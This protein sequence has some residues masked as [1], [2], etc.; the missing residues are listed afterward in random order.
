METDTYVCN[1]CGVEMKWEETDEVHG[2]IWGCE[3][4]GSVFCS[5]CFIERHGRKNYDLMMR[6]YGLIYC[7][8]CW[9]NETRNDET[10]T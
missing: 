1:L 3:K 8:S 6:G 2:D 4:C 5:K 9:E 10:G 7:P